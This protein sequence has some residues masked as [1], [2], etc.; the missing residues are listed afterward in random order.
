MRTP[1]ETGWVAVAHDLRTPLAALSIAV[2]TALDGPRWGARSPIRLLDVM[3]RNLLLMQ[4]LV[5]GARRATQNADFRREPVDVRQLLGELAGLYEP[6]L[7]SRGQT[8]AIEHAA[9]RFV[10]SADRGSL[11]RVLVNLIDNAS[12]FGP[13]GDRVR[14]VLKRRPGEVVIQVCDHGPGI[15]TNE[16]ELVF[17]PYYRGRSAGAM[18]GAGLG[19]A[20]VRAVVHAH[21][22]EVHINRH[23]H[24]TR[25]CITLPSGDNPRGSD[26]AAG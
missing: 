18:P 17:R 20:T 10:V 4:E 15:P 22:G 9:D 3:R 8:L 25:L 24:E 26:V 12:K 1:P 6:L 19:L 2:E 7:R 16:R 23:R 5:E 11:L 13:Q 14:V 21:G